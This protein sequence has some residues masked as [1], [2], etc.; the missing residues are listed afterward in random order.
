MKKTINLSA[1]Q[2]LFAQ[3]R[4]S[5]T[6]AYPGDV[7]GIH[8]PG[9]RHPT[10]LTYCLYVC[11]YSMYIPYPTTLSTVCMYVCTFHFHRPNL[12]YVQYVCIL[13]PCNSFFKGL[14][15]I[16]DTIYTGNTRITYPGIPSF[17]PEKFAYIRNPNPS[18]YKKFQKVLPACFVL[19]YRQMY[20]MY[21]C[22]YDMLMYLTY[23]Y[24]VYAC[25]Y[26]F[27]YIRMYVC[28]NYANK[29]I[30][31][32]MY[33]CIYDFLMYVSMYLY[34]CM[35]INVCMYFMYVGMYKMN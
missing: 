32:C 11:M 2:S 26:A 22:M 1:A 31:L 5:I 29:F 35:S 18:T 27:M 19:L 12:L 25:M 14:F 8:N 15:A 10:D 4:E 3:D 17:S 33:V 24:S 9:T 28:I 7:I 30:Y 6:E 23:S 16:G 34:V 20:C 13:T 21:V